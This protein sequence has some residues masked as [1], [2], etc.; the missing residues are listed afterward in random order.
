LPFSFPVEA[1]LSEALEPEVGP[2]PGS[3][4]REPCDDST[5]ISVQEENK[6]SVSHCI[7]DDSTVRE[8]GLFSQKSFLVLGFSVENKCNIV[9][10]IREHAGKIVSLPS[11]IVA[12]YAVVPLL[13]CEVDVTVGE[14]VTNTWL[15]R[16]CGSRNP[17]LKE[18]W[19]PES[20]CLLL[21]LF[22]LSKLA[23]GLG[24]GNFKTLAWE[25][26][27]MAQWVEARAVGA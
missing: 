26:S 7:L 3:A 17:V 9:D 12:D 8:E 25:S 22:C 1:K 4:H 20:L 18:Y 21:S 10:I 2:C 14:V 6:S 5:H 11:R 16:S 27:R 15:V 19:L 13:G 24:N 23:F